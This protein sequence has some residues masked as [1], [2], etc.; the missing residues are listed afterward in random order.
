MPTRKNKEMTD[1]EKIYEDLRKVYGVPRSP[2]MMDLL[3]FFF[4]TLEE[5]ELG[6]HLENLYSGGKAKTIGELA[7]ETGMEVERVRQL[8]DSISRKIIIKWREREGQ[9]GVKEY[10][11]TGSRGLKNAW[12]HVGKDD[13]EGKA[14]RGLI[15]KVLDEQGGSLSI[16]KPKTLIL[17]KT[18]HPDTRTLPYEIASE[19]IKWKAKNKVSIALMW[20]N[21]REYRKKCNRRVDNCIAFGPLADF[22]VEAAK[23]T[24]G[25]KAV[26]YVSGEEALQCLDESLKQGLVAQ[27]MTTISS[28][29]R[30]T[31]SIFKE[32]SGI[33]LCCSCCCE[34]LSRYVEYGDVD[35]LP[36]FVPETDQEKCTLCEV[37]VKICPVKARW[38]HWPTKADL[39]DDFIFLDAE[40]CIG[41]GLCAYHCKPR[42]V[43]MVRAKD[44]KPAKV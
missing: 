23:T 7:D 29:E 13:A 17:D 33:C 38:H 25:S 14:F 40:K 6:R 12:G 19:I 35:R 16:Y 3:Q 39:S 11:N 18:I 22:Y 43:K 5:A 36:E 30:D 4:P 28:K 1:E 44:Q 41:C 9:H 21:C 26:N 31:E 15:N 32:I 37:C 42:A 27:V 34:Q 10:Y 24:P 8:V 20:C 2:A